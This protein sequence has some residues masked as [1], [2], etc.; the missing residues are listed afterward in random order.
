MLYRI[1]AVLLAVLALSGC[2][3]MLYGRNHTVRL[4]DFPDGTQLT[5][6]NQRNE[7]VYVDE[8]PDR[9]R[10]LRMVE[11]NEAARYR[12]RFEHPDYHPRDIYVEPS[13][14]T[15]AGVLTGFLTT[16]F[17]IPP[18]TLVVWAPYTVD[19]ATGSRAFHTPIRVTGAE[20]IPL[21]PEA[22]LLEGTP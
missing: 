18:A 20:L 4:D 21:T 5:V 8:V 13:S 7:Q 11:R 2:A 22:E 17:L 12:M 19:I 10:L 14:A 3:T 6:V 16:V 15:L 9:L 1:S